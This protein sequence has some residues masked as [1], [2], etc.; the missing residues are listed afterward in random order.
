MSVQTAVQQMGQVVHLMVLLI[1][2]H[3]ILVTICLMEVAIQISVIALMVTEL[4][5]KVV[6][7]MDRQNVHHA[8]LDI[9]F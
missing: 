9:S 4:L 5:G 7:L 2:N 8:I 3:A 6:L 1:V